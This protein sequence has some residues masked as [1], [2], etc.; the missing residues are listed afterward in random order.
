MPP[1]HSRRGQRRALG[2]RTCPPTSPWVPNSRGLEGGQVQLSCGKRPGKG[3]GACV[4][5]CAFIVIA[6]YSVERQT[7]PMNYKEHKPEIQRN[8]EYNKSTVS[9]QPHSPEPHPLTQSPGSLWKL[10]NGTMTSQ[11]PQKISAHENEQSV[12]SERSSPEV[13]TTDI[14]DRLQGAPEADPKQ[15]QNILVLVEGLMAGAQG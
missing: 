1:S 7:N 2:L 14:M 8:Q 6:Q 12:A 15:P 3:N 4:S 11:P 10:G 9:S 5:T 13:S